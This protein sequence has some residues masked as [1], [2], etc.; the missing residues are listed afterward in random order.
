MDVHFGPRTEVTE[1]RSDQG[2]KW[3][4]PFKTTLSR[5]IYTAVDDVVHRGVHV[6]GEVAEKAEHREPGEN[7]GEE[8]QQRHR[9]RLSVQHSKQR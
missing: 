4:Y 5:C 6:P 2:P 9:D 1:D 8:I 3:M 7:A